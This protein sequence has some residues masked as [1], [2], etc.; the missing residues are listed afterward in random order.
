[1]LL[2][3]IARCKL[4]L[5]EPGDALAAAEEAV[6]IMDAR[7]LATCALS[8]PIALA[9]VLIATQGAAAAERIDAVL[10]RAE[11]VARESGARAFEPQIQR[12]RAALAR[13]RGDDVTAQRE[14]A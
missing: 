7:G 9:Q 12:E 11:R 1:M 8:A 6:D 3:T 2:A 5:G 4:A 13:L 10:A 14:R